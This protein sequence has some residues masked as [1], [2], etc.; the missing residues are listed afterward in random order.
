MSALCT[1]HVDDFGVA[2]VAMI[3]RAGHNCF[4]DAFVADLLGALE[5][6]AADPRAR[7][8]ILTG[9]SEIW[10][11]GGS[12][13]VLEDVVTGARSPYELTL[14]RALLEFPLPTIAAMEGAAIGGGFVL[15][16]ACDLVVLAERSRYGCNF[17]DLGFTPGMG[18]TRLLEIALGAPLAAEVLLGASF[19]R[20][21]HFRGRSLVNY[22]VPRAEVRLQ[23]RAIALS[24]TDKPRHALVLLKRALAASKRRA[25]EE[26][27]DVEALM[28]TICFAHADTAA[29]L[30]DNYPIDRSKEADD[31]RP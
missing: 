20:G 30:R 13:E 10:C 7:V 9:L 31:A 21:S 26:A 24:M 18:A 28:H 27:R 23:A 14:T 17:M 2:W 6:A 12:L 5:V 3:D 15:G 19:L 4:T 11:G 25:F 1:A 8:A 29:I 22:V 16:L